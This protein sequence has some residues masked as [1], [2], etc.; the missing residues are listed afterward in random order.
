M[1]KMIKD[2]SRER[3]RNERNDQGRKRERKK[4]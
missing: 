2:E 4:Q 1:K 3:K